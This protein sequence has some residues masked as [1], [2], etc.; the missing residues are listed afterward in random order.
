MSTLTTSTESL[1]VGMLTFMFKVDPSLAGALLHLTD[2]AR[3]FTVSKQGSVPVM[4]PPSVTGVRG[5]G[6]CGGSDISTMA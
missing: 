2:T 5:R 1:A 4:C 3:T 6:S